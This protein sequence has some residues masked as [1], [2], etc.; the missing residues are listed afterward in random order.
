MEDEIRATSRAKL[1]RLR[2]EQLEAAQRLRESEQSLEDLRRRE[3]QAR[4]AFTGE[5]RQMLAAQV[6]VPKEVQA[7]LSRPLTVELGEE[8]RRL[9]G[10]LD[11]L[12]TACLA[13]T[14]EV[15]RLRAA[16]ERGEGGGIPTGSEIQAL[17]ILLTTNASVRRFLPPA[18]A[19]SAAAGGGV[20]GQR[21]SVELS[22]G[23]RLLQRW[24]A[25]AARRAEAAAKEAAEA[26]EREAEEARRVRAEEAKQYAALQSREKA[27]ERAHLQAVTFEP[28]LP[29]VAEA[30]EKLR[31]HSAAQMARTRR[32]EEAF[33]ELR[34]DAAGGGGGGGSSSSSGAGAGGGA[35]QL[36]GELDGI[37]EALV[38][39]RASG[40]PQDNSGGGAGDAH[41]CAHE[42]SARV[43]KLCHRIDAVVKAASA[44]GSAG[45]G[46]NVGLVSFVLQRVV[47]RGI[48]RSALGVAGPG[49]EASGRGRST[50]ARLRSLC[51]YSYIVH[52]LCRVLGPKLAA[53]CRGLMLD[54]LQ[55]YAGGACVPDLATLVAADPAV[56]DA[57]CDAL[58]G[59]VRPSKNAEAGRG[60][61]QERQQ[62]YQMQILRRSGD[63]MLLLA[64]FIRWGSTGDATVFSARDAGEW[65]SRALQQ[66]VL[67]LSACSSNRPGDGQTLLLRSSPTLCILLVER[68][69]YTIKQF[70]LAA[71]EGLLRAQGVRVAGLAQMSQAALKAALGRLKVAVEGSG[72]NSGTAAMCLQAVTQHVEEGLIT[73]LA[74]LAEGRM[75]VLSK[76][77][78]CGGINSKITHGCTQA[79]EAYALVRYATIRASYVV[80]ALLISCLCVSCACVVS[81]VRCSASR[82]WRTSWTRT[83]HLS[84]RTLSR[85]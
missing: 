39:V 62:R 30:A 81:A 63:A 15:V 34:A 17:E 77:S 31:Q 20:G 44:L 74:P 21:G 60:T 6:L 46:G 19:T 25:E 85:R 27:M 48:V 79:L 70:V 59:L 73:A 41:L 8:G 57:D 40:V 26:S 54:A 37:I 80:H 72:G 69:C 65:L 7:L 24:K 55:S 64:T 35:A 66:T 22:E 33:P 28:A 56:K 16:C 43:M 13:A 12:W 51:S 32:C 61:P 10:Q 75:A 42:Y 3:E 68:A 2:V 49:E 71:G 47:D 52:A 38:A 82:T 14:A 18:T 5:L 53:S 4:Q 29:Y 45:G 58:S 9:R 36:R 76:L 23:L 83:P 78:C 67:L 84:R 1:A 50:E 11:G